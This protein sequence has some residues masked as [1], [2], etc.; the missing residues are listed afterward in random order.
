VR[1]GLQHFQHSRSPNGIATS[2]E[3]ALIAVKLLRVDCRYDIF[4]DRVDVTTND[5]K[6]TSE[7]YEGFDQI[8]LLLRREALLKWGFDPG[9][10]FTEDALRLEC[11]EHT[12]DPVREY[13]DGLK[14]DGKP[15]IDDWLIRYCD[16]AD[17]PLNRAF[18]RK[19][20]VA[21]V[22][23]VRQPGCKF[24]FMLVL[25]GHQGQGKSTML[26][27]LA[28]GD[29]N[30]SDAEIIGSDKREQQEAVVG[31]WIYEIAEL[32]GMT[33]HDVTKIKLFLSKTHDRA[34][35]AYGRARVDR[36]RRCV[37]AGTTNDD[38]CL[39]DTTGNRR[40]W[41]VLCRVRL[42]DLAAVACDRDQ[43][44]AEAAFFE[45]KGEPLTIPLELWGAA[46]I[47]QQA[48]VSHDAWDDVLARYLAGLR[49]DKVK[50]GAYW[51]G[52]NDNGDREWRVASS[53]LL[54]PF[55]LG[56]EVERQTVAVTKRLAEVMRTLGWNK[57]SQTIRV[58]NIP[59]R[60]FTKAIDAT[61]QVAF[62]KPSPTPEAEEPKAI[63]VATPRLIR[64][65]IR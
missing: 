17:T 43:L 60:G 29:E 35:P 6:A 2:F 53:Y 9:K 7:N 33:K 40:Y 22:R 34:R 15:R 49:D 28:G 23:R 41:P 55:V 1:G 12:F 3:N 36:A 8:A 11:L 45:A 59:C 37:F 46:S 63:V 44:W 30:F 50:D 51:V 20:F 54:G 38:N 61:P 32:E 13:L 27:I 31:V 16:A 57:P 4:H 39:R 14:W 48:R 62:V 56:I 42:I 10:L 5:D 52:I 18:G 65:L 19:F 58:G 21:A 24:D 26:K 47:E 25:E 64:R